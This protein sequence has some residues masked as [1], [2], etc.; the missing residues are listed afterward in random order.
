[1]TARIEAIQTAR[2]SLP[3]AKDLVV[4]GARGSHDHSDFLLV[5]VI[6]SDGVEGYGEVS[7]TPL[8]SGEDGFSADH[9]IREVITPVLKGQP[10]QPVALLDNAMDAVLAGNPF[11]KAGVSIA[12]W[13]AY[14]RTLNVPL[15]TALGGPFRTEIPIKLSLSGDGD[16]LDRVYAA[17]TS[18]GFQAFKVKVGKGVDG[19]V[20]RV[21]QARKLAGD[22][23]F[24]GVDA[25]TGWSRAEAQQAVR[26]MAPYGIAFVEQPL[27]ADDLD[28]MRELR[29]LGY[30]VVADESVFGL[31]DLRRVIAADAADVIS[32][33]VGKAGGPS[34]AVELGRI[35]H[36]FGRSSLIGS[37]GELGL[38]AAAQ[39]HVAAAIEGLTT[40]FPSDIIGAHYY[41]EDIL[42]EPLPSDGKRVTLPDGPGLGVRLRDDLLGSFR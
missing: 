8:W 7:A 42:A 4:Q 17:A 32:V 29:G 19:D 27:A 36:A 16:Y 23:T 9:F 12:L 26:R 2:I 15:A 22:H 35:A 41:A 34:R 33:Y 39:A 11:T 30:P 21:E 31:A 3:V 6:T 25:N 20:A 37:N 18:A 28:G 24:L 13:D 38:G 1:M 5:R 10:L 40:A 14:A